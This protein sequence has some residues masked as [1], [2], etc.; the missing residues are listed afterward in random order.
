MHE[1]VKRFC[2]ACGSRIAVNEKICSSCGHE[3]DSGPSTLPT[4][5]SPKPITPSPQPIDYRP[6]PNPSYYPTPKSNKPAN[7][8]LRIIFSVLFFIV[9]NV[10]WIV[11]AFL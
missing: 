3:L 9:I 11:L 1:N 10:I 6:N 2:T 7:R 4:V 8:A 5:P